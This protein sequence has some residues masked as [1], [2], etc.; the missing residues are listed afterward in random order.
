VR[1]HPADDES[2]SGDDS[3]AVGQRL[4]VREEAVLRLAELVEALARGVQQLKPPSS[5]GGG[6][7]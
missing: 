6:G 3:Y 5:V 4:V 1:V 2:G 7:T